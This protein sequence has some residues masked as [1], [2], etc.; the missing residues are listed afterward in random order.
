[1]TTYDSIERDAADVVERRHRRT[2]TLAQLLVACVAVCCCTL[3]ATTVG[4]T[5]HEGW[6]FVRQVRRLP[7]AVHFVRV[8]SADEQLKMCRSDL[9]AQKDV[10]KTCESDL[11]AQKD[12]LTTCESDL[13]VQKDENEKRTTGSAC[14]ESEARAK[15]LWRMVD[16]FLLWRASA[17]CQYLS[18]ER[19]LYDKYEQNAKEAGQEHGVAGYWTRGRATLMRELQK[20]SDFKGLCSRIPQIDQL[21][22]YDLTHIRSLYEYQPDGDLWTFVRKN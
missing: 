2:F 19:Q 17:V 8:P 7:R 9:K 11:K 22:D 6:G 1:M 3:A 4:S 18:R 20:S 5:P 14:T 15:E 12:V 13:K 10:L 21:Y 16:S